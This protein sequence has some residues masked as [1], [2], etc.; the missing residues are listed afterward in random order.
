M[1][2]PRT[3]RLTH[4]LVS[5]SVGVGVLCLATSAIGRTYRL[6]ASRP[7]ARTNREVTRADLPSGAAHVVAP[8]EGAAKLIRV[9]ISGPIEQR[10]GYHDLCGGWSDGHDAIAERLCAALAEGDVLLVID[11]PGGAVAG[12]QQAVARVLKAKAHHGRRITGWANEQIGSAAVWW[13]LAVCDELFIPPA[14]QVGSIG[15][16]GGHLSIA[17]AM[18]KAGEKLTYFVWPD[19]GKI[20]FAPELPL[21]PIGEARGNRD[22]AIAGE[23]FAA[24]VIAGPIGQRHGLTRDAVVAMSADMHTGQAA[25][26]KGLAD[27]V[28]SEDEVI[29]YALRLADRGAQDSS[30]AQAARARGGDDMPG[31]RSEDEQKDARGRAEDDDKKPEG[32]DD[33]PPPSGEEPGRDIPT[34]CASCR[35]ENDPDAKYCK[36][37]GASMA[38]TAEDPPDAEEPPPSSKPIPPPAAR[39]LPA[40]VSP[41]ASLAEVLGLDPDASLPAQ[42]SAAMD[43]RQVYDYAASITGQR[44]AA[45]VLGGLKAV[46]H[47]AA[48][49]GRLRAE[50]NAVRAREEARDR[51]NL[52]RRLVACGG[53]ERGRVFVDAV[54]PDGARVLD[55][56]G[57]PKVTLAR[58]YREMRIETLRGEVE[59]RERNAA[60]RSPFEPDE[61]RAAAASTGAKH[62]DE[63]AR[64]ERAK[65]SPVVVAAFNRPGNRLTID[66]LAAA[67]VAAGLDIPAN[68]PALPGVPR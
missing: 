26:D 39:A 1:P 54:T 36:G 38:T 32:E 53:A 23:A 25:V 6:H 19:E 4:E 13:A 64:V 52:C 43:L 45:G 46:A 30:G 59:N 16:R 35:V 56:S 66:Q 8:V 49:S 5:S 60:P 3:Y 12:L 67:H 62:G 51:W 27:G 10:A 57:R 15:A 44:S 29:A 14:G 33:A 21:G 17:G 55:K 11:S 41:T 61:E 31:M 20:A 37:C 50:R 34:A 2:A 42:K 40:R 22:V 9:E 63:K 48:Q 24:A 47:D 68:I 65:Q 28:A 18:E 58:V 7:D